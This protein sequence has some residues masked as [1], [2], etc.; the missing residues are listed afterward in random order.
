MESEPLVRT[1]EARVHGRYLV[2][3]PLDPGPWPALFSFHGYGEDATANIAALTRI[4]N[5]SAW[6]LIAVQ[7]LHPFYTKK[8]AVVASWMTRQDRDLAIPDNV[9]YVTAVAA[10]VR[11]EF[12]LRTSPVVFA[13]FSQGVAMAYRAA[14][15]FPCNGVIALAGDVP[16]DVTQPLP[17]VLIGRGSQD[18]WYTDEKVAADLA[19]LTRLSPRVETCVFAG[20]HEWTDAFAEAAGA[21]LDRVRGASGAQAS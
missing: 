3:T 21:F 2:R 13:G 5:N 14:A 20:G 17:E 1:I 18:E 10:A 9:G 6:L 8:Q 19:R 11:D 15:H 7:A 16:P 12:R 4:P